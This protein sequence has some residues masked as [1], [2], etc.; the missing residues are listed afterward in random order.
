[1]PGFVIP[2]EKSPEGKWFAAE[3]LYQI[4]Y[5]DFIPAK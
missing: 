4:K 5:I 1:M 3:S 2:F